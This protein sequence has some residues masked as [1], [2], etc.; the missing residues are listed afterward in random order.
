[1]PQL[2]LT[3]VLSADVQAAIAAA[4]QPNATEPAEDNPTG[5][6]TWDTYA[7]EADPDPDPFILAGTPVGD[8]VIT[9][10]SAAGIMMAGRA[11]QEGDFVGIIAGMTGDQ[12]DIMMELFSHCDTTTMAR[13]L[14]DLVE[15]FNVF[16]P[17]KMQRGGG[18]IVT[19]R[20]PQEAQALAT[21]GFKPVGEA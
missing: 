6:H 8:I 7:A 2:D 9:R 12:I 13:I 14:G 20:T 17:V 5:Y 19:A 16:T 10:P 1:M 18:A 3:N 4:D 21:K 11:L 15:H